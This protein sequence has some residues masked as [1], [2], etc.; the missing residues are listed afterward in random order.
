VLTTFCKLYAKG[1]WVLLGLLLI[2]A[3]ATVLITPDPTDDIQAVVCQDEAFRILV[4]ASVA[5]LT[6]LLNVSL[7]RPFIHRPNLFSSQHPMTPDLL[8]VICVWRC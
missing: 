5:D 4:S 8:R 3:V 2:V 1:R 6:G 7:T